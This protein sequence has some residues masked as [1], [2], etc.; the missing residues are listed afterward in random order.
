LP[1]TAV[2]GIGA[3]NDPVFA[4]G[5]QDTV[6]VCML[7]QSPEH[8]H[9]HEQEQESAGATTPL[10]YASGRSAAGPPAARWPVW[11]VAAA[12]CAWTVPAVAAVRAAGK[13]MLRVPVMTCMPRIPVTT[14][15]MTASGPAWRRNA[16]AKFRCDAIKAFLLPSGSDRVQRYRPWA[17]AVFSG[18]SASWVNEP[19]QGSVS[20]VAAAA[21]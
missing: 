3:D 1:N 14:A 6:M 4:D 16:A 7:V 20:P 12:D 10:P 17:D 19:R 8:E 11:P 13:C 18:G 9:E 21:R 2:P 5:I 15:R